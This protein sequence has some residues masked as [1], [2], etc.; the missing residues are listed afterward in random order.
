MVLELQAEVQRRPDRALG[1]RLC[2]SPTC[3]SRR[4]KRPARTS[5]RTRSR[6]R[7]RRLTVPGRLPR[8]RRAE[9][10]AHQAPRLRPRDAVPDPGRQVEVGVGVFDELM[11]QMR[12][13][14]FASP[15]ETGARCAEHAKLR[16]G[17]GCEPL[18]AARAWRS[19]PSPASA[20]EKDSTH[21]DDSIYA[22][23]AGRDQLAGVVHQLHVRDRDAV[24]EPHHAPGGDEIV[25]AP[26]PQI[27]DVQVDRADGGEM[28]LL[29]PP[30]TSCA[31]RR[32]GSQNPPRRRAPP[33][34]RRHAGSACAHC[35]SARAACRSAASAP[36][37]RPTRPSCRRPC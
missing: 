21:A 33:R 10:L 15:H 2:S 17:R 19:P 9:V 18:I 20:G 32:G 34:S 26:G 29:R 1:L 7:C 8:R 3:S 16:A 22:A 30:R 36:R 37:D 4:P 14:A 24:A 6:S 25:A 13:P 28:A 35:R 31:V 12:I 27:V 5:T 23:L 11:A